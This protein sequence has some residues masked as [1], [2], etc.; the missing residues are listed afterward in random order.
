MN[1]TY[2]KNVRELVQKEYHND[3]HH[4]RPHKRYF[5]SPASEDGE[6][7]YFIVCLNVRGTPDYKPEKPFCTIIGTFTDNTEYVLQYDENLDCIYSRVREWYPKSEKQAI[8]ISYSPGGL[9]SNYCGPSDCT[10]RVSPEGFSAIAHSYD[11]DGYSLS[12]RE[13]EDAEFIDLILSDNV[14]DNLEAVLL[15]LTMSSSE[16]Y[17]GPRN[18]LFDSAWTYPVQKY[19]LTNLPQESK[20]NQRIRQRM[21]DTWHRYSDNK[22]FDSWEDL[23]RDIGMSDYYE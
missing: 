21:S 10:Y 20:V 17:I 11:I 18:D 8:R 2:A 15:Q 13:E 14:R 6:N 1:K 4:S 19:I 3:T 12:M 5:W 7:Q 16:R 23:I 22:Y 9:A